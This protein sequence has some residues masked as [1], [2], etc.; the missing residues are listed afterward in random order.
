[1]LGSLTYYQTTRYEKAVLPRLQLGVDFKHHFS[2]SSFNNTRPI[3]TVQ[4]TRY[5]LRISRTSPSIMQARKIR[6]SDIL[7]SATVGLEVLF[8]LEPT[9]LQ[10]RPRWSL[11]YGTERNGTDRFRHI[12]SRNGTS[13]RDRDTY[14]AV[15]GN[16]DT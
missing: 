1:M 2:K 9:A 10:T 12:I 3:A 11:F 6:A 7:A 14:Y 16:F 13:I 5:T 8:N 4:D 15:L